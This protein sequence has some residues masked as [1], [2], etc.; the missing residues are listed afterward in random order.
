MSQITVQT[1]LP[2]EQLIQTVEQLDASELEQ[3]IAQA[4]RVQNKRKILSLPKDQSLLLQQI[5]Q[6]I[7]NDLQERYNFLISKR[8]DNSLT[9]EEYQELINLGE[10]IEAIDVKRL[11]NLT[12][13][14]KIRQTSLNSV[15]EEFQLQPRAS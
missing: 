11:E 3:L 10:H 6:C 5:T 12:E 13:L 8:Q 1:Q 2:F 7:P 4:I 14:A 9:D 15:I